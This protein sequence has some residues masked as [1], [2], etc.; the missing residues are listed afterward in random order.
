[1]ST[2]LPGQHPTVVPGRHVDTAIVTARKQENVFVGE[3][4]VRHRRSTRLIHWGGA[5]TFTIYLVTGMPIWTPLFAWMAN[6]VG[7]LQVAR[8]IHPY[9]SLLFV[10]FALAQ[11]IGWAEEMKMTP[12]DKEWLGPKLFKFMR[13]EDEAIDTGKY[14]GGQKIFF[15]C[16]TIGALVFL[17][18]GVVM[19][20]PE[21]FPKAL[22]LW[23]VILHD[24][25]FIG[26]LVGVI[27]HIYMGTAA[28][29]GTFRAMTVGTVT[30]AWAKLHHPGWYRDIMAEEAKKSSAKLPVK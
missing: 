3:E 13:Y 19:W 23:A 28:E 26:F 8:L 1:M 24:L 10:A 15:Y 2:V 21:S 14:N 9:A 12:Q 17:A 20:F 4:I 5:A 22:R 7:G 27:S 18:S 29:P 25:A 6:I 30:R 11:F 16:T